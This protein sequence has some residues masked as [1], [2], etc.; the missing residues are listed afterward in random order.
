MH[1]TIR[2]QVTFNPELVDWKTGNGEPIKI[3][4]AVYEPE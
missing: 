4:P 2:P 1:F 3:Y